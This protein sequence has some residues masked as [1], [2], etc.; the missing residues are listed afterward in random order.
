M[1]LSSSGSATWNEYGR[2]SY[3]TSLRLAEEAAQGNADLGEWFDCKSSGK[4]DHVRP[5]LPPGTALTSD[6]PGSI[7]STVCPVSACL[8]AVWLIG[9][10]SYA[11]GY[12]AV[13]PGEGA[14]W[15]ACVRARHGHV[16][17]PSVPGQPSST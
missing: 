7:A 6:L 4:P 9:D 5:P 15:G 16:S 13:W 8:P 2:P 11:T 1:P 17:P 3:Y 10:V 12:L 14:A